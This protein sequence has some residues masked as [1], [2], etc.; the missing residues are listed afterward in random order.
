MAAVLQDFDVLLSPTLAEPPAPIGR[1][2]PVNTDFM[3]YRNGPNGVFAYSP[4]T[5]VFN[6]SGQ[7]A[8]SLPLHWAEGDL[9]VGVHFAA[10]FGEDEMLMGLARQ[11]EMAMPWHDKQIEL[12]RRLH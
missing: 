3:D 11:I 6:A 2:K 5:A 12:I 8:V 9:P 7:P 4:Y 10:R 1:F